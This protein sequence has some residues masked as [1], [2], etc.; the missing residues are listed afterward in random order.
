M[1]TGGKIRQPTTK[2]MHK[3]SNPEDSQK[4]NGNIQ[5][6]KLALSAGRIGFWE[7]NLRLDKI[8]I[9]SKFRKLLGDK[10]RDLPE[11]LDDWRQ[12]IYS[13]DTARVDNELKNHLLNQTQNFEIEFRIESKEDSHHWLLLKGSVINAGQVVGI[14]MD[15]TN[16]KSK[17]ELAAEQA[18]DYMA[19]L[20]NI[21]IG[22][23]LLDKDGIINSANSSFSDILDLNNEP[24][25]NRIN[26]LSLTLFKETGIDKYFHNLIHKSIVFDFESPLLKTNSGK[27]VYL[28]CKGI[29][30]SNTDRKSYIVIFSDITSHKRIEMQLRQA[31]RLEAIG[32][33]AG[34]VAHDFNN[35]LMVIQGASN[36]I[37]S[38]LEFKDPVYENVMQISKAAERAESLTRQLLAFSRR[39]LM[40]PKVI[41]LNQLIRKM[42]ATIKQI[43]GEDIELDII[44]NSEQGHIKVDPGQMEQV[45]SNLLTNARDAMPNGGK[46]IIETNSVILD[47]TYLK[48][49]PVVKTG[50]YVMLVITDSGCGMNKDTL[51][52]IFEPFFSTKEKGKGSGMGLAT[53]YGIVKQSDG[54][55]WVYS[56]LDMGTTF[57]IYLPRVEE[58][59]VAIEKPV[60]SDQSMRGKETVLV[61]EDEDEVRNLVSEM[62][63]FYGYNVLE[64]ANASNALSIFEKYQKSIDLILTDIIMPQMSGTEL[65]ERI[66]T[67]YPDI[68]VLYMSGYTDNTLVGHGLLADEKYFIQKPFSAANL[69]E[70]VRLIL[71]ES[72]LIE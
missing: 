7:W 9:D 44:L 58:S 24:V 6:L 37:L 49:H 5:L 21:P 67:T 27:Q 15:I 1:G 25:A 70:K 16:V 43:C 66:L 35:I 26:I 61:V 29:S 45:I 33:L 60:I 36:L 62:L 20:Q 2:E 56:E 48:R 53:V 23:A 34:G 65:I 63:R 59:I 13:E 28:H 11:Y 14:C 4:D 40:Q 22:I 38:Q 51:A 41:E 47:E 30:L 52:H 10:D 71:D 31:Q 3:N 32:N 69:V 68:K 46:I 42:D 54:Y 50:S 12:I 39:Q 64:A 72:R 18:H 19:T 8:F 55:I 17:G 57:K